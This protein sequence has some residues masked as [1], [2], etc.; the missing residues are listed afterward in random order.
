MRTRLAYL[1]ALVAAAAAA[2][3]TLLMDRLLPGSVGYLVYLAIVGLSAWRGGL[4]PGL[5][6][7]F[8]SAV[9]EAT[10]LFPPIGIPLISSSGQLLRLALFLFDGV[11]VSAV[12]SSLRRASFAEHQATSEKE[13]LLRAERDSRQRAERSRS[14]LERLQTVTA[15]LAEAAT[16]AEIAQAIL[17]RGLA[18]LGASA[19]AVG[20]VSSDWTSVELIAAH[21]GDPNTR[22]MWSYPLDGPSHIADALRTRGPIL[23]ESRAAWDATYGSAPRVM[24]GLALDGGASATIPLVVEDRTIGVLVLD[25]PTAREFDPET[26]DLMVRLGD[27]S[28]LALDRAVAYEEQGRITNRLERSQAGL[29]WLAH[30]SQILTST[31]D[32]EA[33]IEAIARL[34]VPSIASWCVVELSADAEPIHAASHPTA[35]GVSHLR[36][37]VWLAPTTLGAWLAGPLEA[38]GGATVLADDTGWKARIDSPRALELLDLLGIGAL[39]IVPIAA[40][41][42]VVGVITL[43]SANPMRFGPDDAAVAE[44]LA[45]RVGAAVEQASLHGAVTRFK[46]TVDASLDAVFMYDPVSLALTYVNRGGAALVGAEPGDLIGVSILDLQ[47][48]VSEENFRQQI[49]PLLTGEHESATSSGTMLRRDGGE[50]PVSTFG[51]CIRLREG[52]ATMILAARDVSDELRAQARLAKIARDERLRAAELSAVLEGIREGVLVV[53]GKGTVQ[54]ANEAARR[55][56]GSDLGD[57]GAIARRL[58]LEPGALPGLDLATSGQ[59][60]QLADGR[61]LEWST[62][63]TSFAQGVADEHG[64]STIVMV[65]DVTR[66][67][68]AESARQAFVDVL[69]HELRTPITTI[70]GYSKVLRH[71]AP[72]VDLPD[73]LADIEIEAD[74]LYRIVEDLV[75]LSRME[76]GIEIN[77]EPLL[78][79]RIVPAVVAQEAR[80]WSTIEFE[81]DLPPGL[82]VVTG[83]RTYVEQVL[84]N[85]LSNAAKYGGPGLVTVAGAADANEVAITVLDR[86]AGLDGSDSERLFDLYYRS[87]S[88]AGR[89]AGGGIGLFVCRGLVTAMGGRIWARPRENGGAEFGFSLPRGAVDGEELEELPAVG[90]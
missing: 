74:R 49:R 80:R 30:A 28:A 47:R 46:A 85:L 34:A 25:F 62:Y 71:P 86:G 48:G 13:R 44:N 43:G 60:I 29:V 23:I 12:T 64:R 67:R 90:R 11:L 56:V 17:D 21:V 89:V 58:E 22:T 54:L 77:G 45:G 70:Y 1:F 69:S 27:L 33:T 42:E 31:M 75:A 78:L 68:A 9:L 65:R 41:E 76:H 24:S 53:D 5:L 20:S 10:L 8:A 57:Y 15:N 82:P 88:T 72:D 66:Q 26:R 7:T 16:P 6:A 73:V 37:L 81:T 32:T 35:A 3:V 40:R 79:Q 2:A 18:A 63:P 59:L 61:W 36:E 19:G 55:L 51:Q 50:V 83:E 87:P 38:E 4:G 14:E 52:A 84:R 39:L